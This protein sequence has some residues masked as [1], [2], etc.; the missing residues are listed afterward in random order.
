MCG[1]GLIYKKTG[2]DIRE[3]SLDKFIAPLER[4]G[5]DKLLVS[6]VS[7]RCYMINSILSIKHNEFPYQDRMIRV[8]SSVDPESGQKLFAFNGEI[9]DW[10]TYSESENGIDTGYVQKLVQQK[11]YLSLYKN[12]SGFFSFIE[13]SFDHGS[14]YIRYGTDTLGEK[15]LFVY[16]DSD[17]IIVC[18]TIASIVSFLRSEGKCVRGNLQGLSRYFLSRHY[19]FM[20]DSPFEGIKKIEGGKVFEYNTGKNECR[21]IYDAAIRL[22]SESFDTTGLLDVIEKAAYNDAVSHKAAYIF[23]GGIDSS[24][25]ASVGSQLEHT[26]RCDKLF[27]TLTFG[28]RDQAALQAREAARSIGISDFLE[29]PVSIEDYQD[30]L[31]RFY[32]EY[33]IPAPTHSFISNDILCSFLSRMGIRLLYGGEG[34]DEL[35][36]GYE[37]YMNM[38][39]D[40]GL[41]IGS[42]SPYSRVESGGPLGIPKDYC[43][44]ED[45]AYVKDYLGRFS[46]LS[47]PGE[48]AGFLLDAT[49]QLQ[50]TGNLCADLTGSHHGI[51]S[52]SPFVNLNNLKRLPQSIDSFMKERQCKPD[53]RRFFL[54]VFEDRYLMPKQGYSGYP[55]EAASRLISSKKFPMCSEL[56]GLNIKDSFDK[57]DRSLQ[58]KMYNMELFIQACL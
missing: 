23:S 50:S 54:S 17:F 37:A 12:Y 45:D 26:K 56:L 43:R 32:R 14:A 15:S 20:G 58:W 31:A 48:K 51:E 19:L 33:F 38:F 3:A 4:R 9:Y 6:R 7:K 27:V 34:A 36:Q 39:L 2:G 49:I 25:T 5:P 47:I 55:N 40:N 21:C 57:L 42:S 44:E 13:V 46:R 24:L 10:D 1:V 11:N 41:E 53:L 22:E 29:I 52:R 8:S 30:A 28:E 18:S 16:S 35:F